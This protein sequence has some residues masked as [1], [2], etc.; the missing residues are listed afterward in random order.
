MR[1]YGSVIMQ[2][3]VL[4]KFRNIQKCC[5]SGFWGRG[6]GP[7]PHLGPPF[8]S[9]AKRQ[10]FKKRREKMERRRNCCV[11]VCVCVLWSLCSELLSGR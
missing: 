5:V 3:N 2:K 7:W 1:Q 4:E 11:C 6:H 10:R 8:H 9:Q